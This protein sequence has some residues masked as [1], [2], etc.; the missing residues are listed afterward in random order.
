MRI[1]IYGTRGSIAVSG[2]EYAE[3]G[4]STSC[5]LVAPNE[6]PPLIFDAGTGIRKLG[7]E[8]ASGALAQEKIVVIVLSH[9]HWDH[10][11]GFPFFDPAYIP[12]FR[13]VIGIC[14]RNRGTKNLQ[15]VFAAQ[16]QDQFFPV[17]LDRMGA[18]FEFLQPDTQPYTGP[19]GRQW[20][21]TEHPHPG[22]AYSYRLMTE[23]KTFV[24]CTDVEHGD[25][26]DPKVV[27]VARGADLLIHEAQ[28]TAEELKAKKG[29]GH[30]SWEQAVEVAK[31]AEVKR[32]VLFHH[33]PEHDDACLRKI[34]NRC[35]V[36]FPASSLAREGEEFV[37]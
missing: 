14:G 6:G 37:L 5:V 4:G 31:R 32:L 23:G 10:I 26:I 24:Y 11:Q 9:T 8:I 7:K 30:S 12:G 34:E 27:H 19:F 1:V 20:E 16:M 2:R 15:E 35:R 13:I 29:W 28:Y 36:R 33:D 25:S 18:D 22:R 3:F 17:P 21:F